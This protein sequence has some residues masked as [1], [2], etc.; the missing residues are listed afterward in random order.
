M[1]LSYSLL[2]C[3]NFII[4]SSRAS[5]VLCAL[6]RGI[7]FS[8]T[9]QLN[10]VP[11]LVGEVTPA[12]SRRPSAAQNNNSTSPYSLSQAFA[13][14]QHATKTKKVPP[15]YITSSTTR[16]FSHT[17]SLEQNL[18]T[19]HKRF[20]NH[21][22]CLQ[23]KSARWSGR[24]RSLFAV[25]VHAVFYRAGMR[26]GQRAGTIPEIERARCEAAPPICTCVLVEQERFYRQSDG[27][28]GRV[29]Y[30][31]DPAF[32]VVVVAVAVKVGAAARGSA[33]CRA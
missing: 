32:Q 11:A 9:A 25:C 28:T 6:R 22:K 10:Y 3:P 8:F 17:S 4:R 13:N 15:I 19:R 31:M 23:G 16:S 14:A 26:A 2:M 30:R 1:I 5:R 12:F 27:R 24:R 29:C 7:C 18:S 33:G 20:L 21:N